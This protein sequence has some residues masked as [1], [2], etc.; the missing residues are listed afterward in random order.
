[1]D[2]IRLLLKNKPNFYFFVFTD[3]D[4]EDFRES[5]F[6]EQANEPDRRQ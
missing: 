5:K 4:H 6:G 3:A 2:K 1:M